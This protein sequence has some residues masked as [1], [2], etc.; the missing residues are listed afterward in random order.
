MLHRVDLIIKVMLMTERLLVNESS[1]VH[2]F[3]ICAEKINLY[4]Y[5]SANSGWLK[6]VAR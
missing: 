5:R 2:K 6:N 1:F 4:D 3:G